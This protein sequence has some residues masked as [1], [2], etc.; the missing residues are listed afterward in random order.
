MNMNKNNDPKPEYTELTYVQESADFEAVVVP[1]R[2]STQ[3]GNAAQ[4]QQQ[5]LK[6]N[7]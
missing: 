7:K 3:Q 1:I 4:S 6:D 5:S 2:P